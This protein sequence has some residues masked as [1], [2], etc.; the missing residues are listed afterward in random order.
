MADKVV[1]P[2]RPPNPIVT[3]KRSIHMKHAP[4]IYTKGTGSQRVPVFARVIPSMP[5]APSVETKIPLPPSSTTDQQQQPMTPTKRQNISPNTNNDGDDTYNNDTFNRTPPESPIDPKV[6]GLMIEQR[7]KDY[8]ERLRERHK[9]I[10]V[11]P[12][13]NIL[14]IDSTNTS[15][16]KNNN[17]NRKRTQKVKVVRDK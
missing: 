16:K 5:K 3:G 8:A 7:R 6:V 15:R 2:R 1:V 10:Y 9:R 4:I 17:N 14:K 13:H 12:Q 11:K